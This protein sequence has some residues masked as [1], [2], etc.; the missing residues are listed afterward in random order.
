MIKN[1]YFLKSFYRN[2][3]IIN[4]DDKHELEITPLLKL[5]C[6]NWKLYKLDHAHSFSN[7]SFT[8]QNST[9]NEILIFSIE[10]KDDRDD[11]YKVFDEEG[12]KNDRYYYGV[13]LETLL[14]K[15]FKILT[16]SS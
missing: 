11:I 2:L 16:S 9:T 10:Y 15:V 7:I 13:E 3:K 5:N 1:L 4:I 6:K 8:L 12:N 14:K